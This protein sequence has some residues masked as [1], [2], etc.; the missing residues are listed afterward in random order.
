MKVDEQTQR[1]IEKFHIAE[2]LGFVNR[3]DSFD[4]FQLHKKTLID[5][6]IQFQ[7]F[8]EHYAFVFNFDLHLTQTPFFASLGA[9]C[10]IFLRF[11]LFGLTI[12]K[13]SVAIRRFSA[14]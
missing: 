1:C 13:V 5:I 2:E 11:L 12:F 8:C 14:S 3:E 6:E 7:R 10:S 4:S 9:F